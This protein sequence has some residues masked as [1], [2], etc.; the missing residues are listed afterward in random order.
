MHAWRP[1]VGDQRPVIAAVSRAVVAREHVKVACS[2]RVHSAV[3]VGPRL[4]YVG[5]ETREAGVAR[6][7]A[8]DHVLWVHGHEEVVGAVALTLPMRRFANPRTDIVDEAP[9]RGSSEERL[10]NVV[11]EDARRRA[12]RALRHHL[13]PVS[14]LLRGR[15]R[16]RGK[17]FN[18]ALDFRQTTQNPRG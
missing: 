2:A 3:P 16:C 6:H 9:R 8:V 11:N 10:W 5:V 17:T 12:W 14:A 7:P 1:L 15:A 4:A 18:S 13:T